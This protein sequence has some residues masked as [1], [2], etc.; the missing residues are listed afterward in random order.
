[1][2]MFFGRGRSDQPS[3]IDPLNLLPGNR[4]IHP[5]GVQPEYETCLLKM[6]FGIR[7][8]TSDELLFFTT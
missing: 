4:F 5:K 8:Y 2:K 7:V 1:M 6:K 3:L